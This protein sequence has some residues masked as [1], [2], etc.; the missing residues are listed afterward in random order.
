MT[1]RFTNDIPGVRDIVPD[2]WFCS[3]PGGQPHFY[4]L[5]D[6]TWGDG[7]RNGLGYFDTKEEIEALLA[8]QC[9]EEEFT[10]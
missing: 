1:I 3:K 7:T 5:R 9:V 8:K 4:L 2:K 6:G 10:G